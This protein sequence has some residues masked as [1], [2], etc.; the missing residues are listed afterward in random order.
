M[1]YWVRRLNWKEDLDR[2][3]DGQLS[4]SELA[5]AGSPSA[6]K[7]Y[8]RGF[9]SPQDTGAGRRNI[10]T[11]QRC[12]PGSFQHDWQYGGVWWLMVLLSPSAGW[13]H[14]VRIVAERYGLADSHLRRLIDV[15]T[16]QDNL[17]LPRCSC[18]A[19]TSTLGRGDVFADL[20]F[21][22]V[23]TGQN[24]TLFLPAM[25]TLRHVFIT[26]R[27]D[28]KFSRSRNVCAVHGN[29]LLLVG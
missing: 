1:T 9:G 29:S 15:R 14:L 11:E 19:C 5:M 13:V 22:A 24:H 18:A 17:P 7:G 6:A 23:Q 26:D 12:P 28:T 20:V 10:I 21:C 16:E 3:H 27:G 4:I 8:R 25:Q 2:D